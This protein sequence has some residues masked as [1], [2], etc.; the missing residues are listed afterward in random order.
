MKKNWIL[1]F[2]SGNG[3]KHTM[4]Q[5]RAYLPHE[6]YIL[7]MDKTNCPYGNKSK[8][9]LKKIVTKTIKKVVQKYDVKL[10]VIACNTISSMFGTYLQKTF[11]ETPFVFVLPIVESHILHKP[12]LILSTKNTAKYNKNLKI[13]KKRKNVYVYGFSNLAK[14]IDDSDGDCEKLQPYLDKKLKK[15][16]NKNIQNV[17]LGCTHFNYIKEQISTAIKSQVS[18]YENSKNVCIK[19]K[20]ILVAAGKFSRKKTKGEIIEICHI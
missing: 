15:Y 16:V 7:F 13:Y 8:H 3:G 18:F 1:V 10:V 14:M 12:T 17:V 2:D 6:N 11:Y 9:K 19:V 20:D 4:E 5:I